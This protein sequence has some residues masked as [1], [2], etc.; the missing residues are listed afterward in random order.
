MISEF[1][2]RIPLEYKQI[3]WIKH[4]KGQYL[5][6]NKILNLL[7]SIIELCVKIKNV[8]HVIPSL[9]DIK[10]K[11]VP[12]A[13]VIEDKMD[14]SNGI[15]LD[16]FNNKISVWILEPVSGILM[17]NDE[18]TQWIQEIDKFLEK[19]KNNIQ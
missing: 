8:N 1:L 5:E 11:L 19:E 17:T 3:I 14:K 15:N 18:R 10:D 12:F 2:Q 6:K 16:E 13:Q 7:Y 4:A 9:S